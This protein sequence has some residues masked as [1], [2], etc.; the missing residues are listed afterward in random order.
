MSDKKDKKQKKLWLSFADLQGEGIV[1][2]W[3]TLR[4]WQKDPNIRFPSG[5]L[6]GPNSRRWN[7]EKEIDPWLE[8]RPV[9]RDAFEDE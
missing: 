3:Q 9:E 1:N 2:N 7:K 4:A 8:T 6:F 5:R